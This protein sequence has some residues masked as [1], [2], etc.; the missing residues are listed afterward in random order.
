MYSDL[1]FL[2]AF[3]FWDCWS[4]ESEESP[5]TT[6]SKRT[7]PHK[8][9]E[10]LGS[11]PAPKPADKRTKVE[12]DQPLPKALSFEGASQPDTPTTDADADDKKVTKSKSMWQLCG[13]TGRQ[14]R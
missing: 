1:S 11:S 2:E 7:E 6:I 10:L 12:G 14:A 5:S 4:K 9:A 13:M 3:H 8:S